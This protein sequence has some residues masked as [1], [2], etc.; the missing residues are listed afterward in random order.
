MAARQGESFLLDQPLHSSNRPFAGL[1]LHASQGDI[2]GPS[3]S[4]LTETHK[5]PKS[6]KTRNIG[7]LFGELQRIGQSAQQKEMSYHVT[8][9]TDWAFYLYPYFDTEAARQFLSWFVSENA[10]ALEPIERELHSSQYLCLAAEMNALSGHTGCLKAGRQK[11]IERAYGL[12]CTPRTMTNWA[13]AANRNMVQTFSSK[14]LLERWI[15]DYKVWQSRQIQP[16]FADRLELITTADH[17]CFSYHEFRAS[18]LT[19][20]PEIGSEH[21]P[22]PEIRSINYHN[23]INVKYGDIGTD[24]SRSLRELRDLASGQRHYSLLLTAQQLQASQDDEL[25]LRFNRLSSASKSSQL[26]DGTLLRESAAHHVVIG[27]RFLG[28][29]PDSVYQV[30]L[31]YG[32][33]TNMENT[34]ELKPARPSSDGVYRTES[35]ST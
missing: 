23:R 6:E 22:L 4:H 31:N 3:T 21:S 18:K 27:N 30:S 11:Q 20:A 24:R 14:P 19:P 25:Y 15:T 8:G 12:A 32:D 28:M 35:M 1:D 26:I 10:F 33:P 17:G 29:Q 16:V 34:L 7:N 5:T 9:R 13:K 2:V